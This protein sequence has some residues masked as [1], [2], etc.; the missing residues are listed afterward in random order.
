MHRWKTTTSGFYTAKL[1]RPDSLNLLL[2]TDP[3]SAY[4]TVSCTVY[5][6]LCFI[7]DQV[8]I[9]FSSQD[10]KMILTIHRLPD[11]H[12]LPWS[13]LCQPRLWPWWETQIFQRAFEKFT[14]LMPLLVSSERSCCLWLGQSKYF[15]SSVVLEN[16]VYS[17]PGYRS[18][19]RLNT[20]FL[21]VCF[22][23]FTMTRLCGFS[24]SF[25]LFFL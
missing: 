22:F 8:R 7:T 16:D 21:I 2:E 13:H 19:P 24:S 10:L 9:Q 11:S 20:G 14:A 25:F 4:I 5:C 23:F 6:L 15:D 18:Q 3:W 17:S 12:Y 1:S